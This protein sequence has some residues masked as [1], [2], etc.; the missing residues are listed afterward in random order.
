VTRA[1]VAEAIVAAA[2]EL[3][4]RGGPEA[5]VLRRTAERA[6]I[7]PSGMYRHVAGRDALLREVRRRAEAALARFVRSALRAVPATADPAEV[8]ARRLRA[9]CT[10][11]IRFALAEPGLYRTLYGVSGAPPDTP[12]S[13]GEAVQRPVTDALDTLVR[14][15]RLPPERR[16]HAETAVLA[17]AR[18]LGLLIVTDRF[19][20]LRGPTPERA[21]RHALDAVLDGV[22]G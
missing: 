13:A 14:H 22:L 19:P 7:T 9:A 11:H 10:G 18:G 21:A 17:C 16:P 3:A 20:G 4:S 5:V 2:T 1:N 12:P 8:A 15:G 6:G